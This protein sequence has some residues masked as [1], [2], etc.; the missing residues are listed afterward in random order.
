LK[1][2]EKDNTEDVVI[3][4]PESADAFAPAFLMPDF[5]EIPLQKA[6]ALSGIAHIIGAVLLWLLAIVPV[7]AGINIPLSKK[8]EQNVPDIKFLL[9][10]S[11][12]ISRSKSPSVKQNVNKSQTK[13]VQNTQVKKTKEFDDSFVPTP[14]LKPL[15][16][17]PGGIHFLREESASSDDTAANE[18]TYG[19]GQRRTSGVDKNSTGIINT[20]DISPYINE[21]QRNIKWN[22]KLPKEQATNQTVELFLRIARDGKLVIFNIKKTSEIAEAD[23]AATDAVKRALPLNPLPINYKKGYLDVVFIFDYNAS[24]IRNKY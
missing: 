19:K 3:F 4:K 20:Y 12:N 8:S 11:A 5:Y 2:L 16:S 6:I 17:S 18:E 1:I 24:A 14:K 15:S 23:N 13:P 21:L 22:W 9:V 10:K 7:F